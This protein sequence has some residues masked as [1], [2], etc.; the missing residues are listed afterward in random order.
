MLRG[1][2]EI[3]GTLLRVPIVRI[4]IFWGLYGTPQFLGNYPFL[5]RPFW[6]LSPHFVTEL[7]GMCGPTTVQTSASVL[8]VMLSAIYVMISYIYYYILYITEACSAKAT[9]ILNA[10]AAQGLPAAVSA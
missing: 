4:I 1:F 5:A 8:P 10:L 2:L 6:Q 3:R 9:M 7:P